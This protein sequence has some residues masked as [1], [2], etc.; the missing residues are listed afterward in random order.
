MPFETTFITPGV[1]PLWLDI[2]AVALGA[3]FGATLANSRV[4]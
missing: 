2:G 1:L 3:L 4:T